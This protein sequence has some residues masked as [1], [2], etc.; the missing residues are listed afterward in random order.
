M[1]HD[2][3]LHEFVL[4][5]FGLE[6]EK[7]IQSR[8]KVQKG[9]FLLLKEL[10]KRGYKVQDPQFVP[11]RDGPYSFVLANALKEL[12]WSNFIETKG[13]YGKENEEFKLTEK[14]KNEAMLLV[15]EKIKENDLKDLITF[16][17]SLD[18]FTVEGLIYYVSNKF[19]EMKVSTRRNKVRF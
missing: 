17:Q 6:L 13:E 18:Q 1:T 3:S 8:V 5:F 14:G 9:L 7:S 12:I 10:E 16:R 11:C 19:P 2:V 15:K 4:I